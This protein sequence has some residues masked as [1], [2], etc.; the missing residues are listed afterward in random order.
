MK[1]HTTKMLD[2]PKDASEASVF[3]RNGIRMPIF[4]L[5]TSHSGGY[6]HEAVIYA[7]RECKYRL[8]D[9]AKRYGCEEQLGIAIKDSCIPRKEIFVTTKLWPTDYGVQTARK[10]C[11][12]STK[13]LNVEYLDLYMMHAPNCPSSCIDK[14]QMR[15]DTWR[16]LEMLLDEGYVKAIGVSN[17]SIAHLEE[18]MDYCGVIPMVNQVEYH[19]F[20]NPYKLHMFCDENSIQLQGYCP[21]AKGTILNEPVVTSIADKM[22]KTPAQILIRWS[23]QNNVVTIPKSTKLARIEENSQV[24]DFSLC[25]EDMNIL[26]GMHDDR[27]I[28]NLSMLQE[29]VD[30]PQPDGYKLNLIQ[31]QMLVQQSRFVNRTS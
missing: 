8:I 13:R 2:I 12:A 10:A 30:N 14:R 1:D 5:G 26:N 19:I 4:G 6:S 21:L 22:K 25:E 20:Q 16:E 11:F 7:L 15:E 24:F 29:K 28:V 3:L 23:I 27:R 31:H 17:F 18:M 9:T